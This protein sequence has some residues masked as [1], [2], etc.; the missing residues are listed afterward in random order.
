MKNIILQIFLGTMSILCIV[1][2]SN[3]NNENTT[4][5]PNKSPEQIFIPE[6][7]E[8]SGL[9]WGLH[10]SLKDCVSCHSNQP[11]LNSSEDYNLIE[12]LPELCYSCHKGIVNKEQWGH[13]PV[14]NG[15]CLLCHEPHK[16]DNKSLLKEPVP[17]LCYQCHEVETLKLIKNHTESSYAR[18]NDCHEHHSGPG[19]MLLKENFYKSAFGLTSVSKN[20]SLLPKTLLLDQ[21]DTLAGLKSIK[22]ELIVDGSELLKRYGV[23]EDLVMINIQK[24]LDNSGI[25]IISDKE[26][27]DSKALLH[28]QLRLIDI[29]SQ[30]NQGDISALSGSFNISLN[31]LVQIL[32]NSQNNKTYFCTATTWSTDA[33]FLWGTTQVK[34]GLNKALDVLIGQFSQDYI[35]IN[36]F[37]STNGDIKSE[38]HANYN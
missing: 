25:K 1:Q 29:P 24:L 27:D 7:V 3:I 15:Q 33:V 8:D 31:Q 5:I 32:R 6:S 10:E 34:E 23:S 30:Q 38:N 14:V 26:Q 9:T 17:Q 16:T 2:A 36:N 18:C 4:L 35:R 11:E 12:S 20:S 22:V 21:R 13:G 19:K 37:E 28:I